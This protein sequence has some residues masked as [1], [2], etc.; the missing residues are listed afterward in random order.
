[1]VGKLRIVEGGGGEPRRYI[2]IRKSQKLLVGRGS[3]ADFVV[4]DREVSRNHFEIRYDGQKFILSDLGSLNGT[5]LNDKRVT[6]T[7]LHSGDLIRIGSTIL[8][9][10][11]EESSEVVTIRTCRVCGRALPEGVVEVCESCRHKEAP[12]VVER[13]PRIVRLELKPDP[14]RP[15][16]HPDHTIRAFLDKH[17]KDSA[18]RVFTWWQKLWY[19][20]ILL[21]MFLLLSYDWLHFLHLT[22][23]FCTF[24][25]VV[26][27]Y[28]LLT[29]LLSVVKRNE[30]VVTEDELAQLSNEEL[31]V[32]T[33]LIPLYKEREVAGK[34]VRAATSLDYPPEKLDIKILLEP[35][36]TQTVAVIEQMELPSNC[37][38]IIVPASQPKTKPK[39]CNHGLERA[40]GEYLVIYDAEDR[41]EPDQ[42]KKAV[43]AFRKVNAPR[44]TIFG[45]RKPSR[46]TICLQAK[47]NYFNQRQN[48]LT[49]WFT[50]EY[51]TWFDLFLPGLHAISAPIPLGG[52]SNHFKTEVL[53]K[54]GGWDPFNVTED[55]D[56]GIRLDKMGYETQVLDSTTWEEA[57][58]RVFN[59]IRQRS[60]WVKGYIQTHLVHM[61]YPFRTI[62]QLG[63]WGTFSFLISVGGLSLML[64]L[65]PIFWIAGAVYL[66][67][68]GI[69]LQNV[70]WSFQRLFELPPE[71]RWSWQMLFTDP[72]GDPLWNT[73]SQVFY[74]ITLILVAGNFFFVLMHV[75]ACI[76]R[77]LYDLIPHAI[78]MPIYWVL[79]SIGAWKGFLQL[80]LKPFYWEKTK[81][82][83]DQPSL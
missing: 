66:V 18:N 72:R 81:H 5:Y 39:A 53:R 67:L 78:V 23:L 57:N 10:S 25:I 62:R 50:I 11:V 6:D 71:A 31:P 42:L 30:V 76:R 69:D 24:Y 17:P 64:L 52:T 83:L 68:L 55:C 27:A 7:T 4:L 41:P 34:I 33:V 28:K 54:I 70:G 32:Y 15:R 43:I 12:V 63:L 51:S 20:L 56:L 77:R 8:E 80:F 16:S 75:L 2:T 38:A 61:R 58:S 82:G 29:V 65:N 36:D 9:F 59:W 73:V 48:L 3:Q 37:E 74:V 19:A 47:L 1:M 13:R 45:M 79:I 22:H 40:R 14:S 49:K 60:R 46:E 44:K 21:A 35:D 26:I